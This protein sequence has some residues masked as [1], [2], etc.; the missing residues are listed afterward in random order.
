MKLQT[1]TPK[2]T[3]TGYLVHNCQNSSSNEAVVMIDN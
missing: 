3:K 2:L 1:I